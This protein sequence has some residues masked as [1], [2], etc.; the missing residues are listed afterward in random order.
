MMRHVF[1]LVVLPLAIGFLLD[2]KNPY[3][4]SNQFITASDFFAAKSGLQNGIEENRRETN[5]LRHDV[6]RKFMVLTSQVQRMFD[7]LQ[8]QIPQKETNQS[9]EIVQ[10]YQE[11]LKNYTLLQKR[12]DILQA[13]Q[14]SQVN[15]LSKC[16]DKVNEH[17]REILALM[18]LKNIQPLSEL[19]SLKTQVQS[20]SSEVH[21]LG[22]SDHARR[23][24]FRALYN[25]TLIS[26]RQTKFRFVQMETNH[27][28]SFTGM[29][30][31]LKDV[32]THINI[33]MS[34]VNNDMT[35]V[36]TS[37]GKLQHLIKSSS[38]RGL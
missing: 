18:N 38:A 3:N 15:E 30:Q 35:N 28:V 8:H 4:S 37:F 26:E 22:E 20:F 10:K 13:N 1:V 2:T 9:D 11:L 12:F 21:A 7:S 36:N 17:D 33:D 23:E 16:K 14:K 25:M 6:D 31:A 24:D 19:S 27:N 32:E 29:Q 34:S 5:N